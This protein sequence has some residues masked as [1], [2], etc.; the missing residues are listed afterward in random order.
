MADECEPCSDLSAQLVTSKG[1][2]RLKLFPN[3]AP[4]TVLNF[5]N[6]A[7]RGFYDGLKFHRVIDNFMI[8][9]GDPN[10]T[11]TGGPGYQFRDEFHSKL[12]H[13]APGTVSMANA[14]PDS[15]GS[16]FFITHTATAWLD[17]KHSIFGKVAE[18]QEIVDA[19]RQGDMIKTVQIEGDPS[20][21][22]EKHDKQVA[23]WNKTLDEKY[24]SKQ[25][26]RAR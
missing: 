10:G 16:Q 3:E 6:L 7:R 22:F 23:K 9:G 18:G 15:N 20:A 12:R 8:Q 26:V 14:G 24:P 1:T 19:T 11:G 25:P 17:R 2:I 21:L 4:L 5:V 13:D